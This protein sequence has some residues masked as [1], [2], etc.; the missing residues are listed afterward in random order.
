MNDSVEFN[1]TFALRSACYLLGFHM[2]MSSCV[3]DSSIQEI[4]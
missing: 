4:G 3:K 2:H 1:P